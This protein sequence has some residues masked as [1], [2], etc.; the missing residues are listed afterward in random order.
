MWLLAAN[1][2]AKES[3][4]AMSVCTT[5]NTF[6]RSGKLATRH[7]GVSELTPTRHHPANVRQGGCEPD[8]KP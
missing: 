8:G 4:V 6:C 5:A 3:M 2:S 1:A 7:K